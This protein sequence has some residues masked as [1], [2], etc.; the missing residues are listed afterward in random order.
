MKY[1]FKR[2]TFL[3]TFS[4]FLVMGLLTLIPLNLHVLDPLQMALTDISFN[5]LSFA[6]LKRHRDNPMDE[7]IVIVNIGNADRATIAAV[8]NKIDEAQPKAIGLD[9][10]FLAPK[11]PLGDS[12]LA[13]AIAQTPGIVL[14][15]KLE[16]E[17]DTAGTENYFRE[18]SNHGGYV[19]FVGEKLGVI[20]YFSPFEKWKDSVNYSF[21][22]AVVKVSDEL[23]LKKLQKRSHDL[24]L[25]NYSREEDQYFTVDYKDLLSGKTSPPV[26]TNKI[27]LIGFVDNN[28]ANIEDKHFTPLNEKFVGKSIPDMNGV[29][30]HANIISMIL[31]DN[32]IKKSP[33][34]LNWFLAFLLTWFF[35][36]FVIKYYVE[37]HLWSHLVLKTIQLLITVLFI[38]L[39]I[40]LG[41]YFSMEVSLTAAMAG[42]ILSV[43]V[44]YFYVGFAIWAHKKF[45]FKNLFTKAH[46]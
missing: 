37:N 33:G 13:K 45:G 2:D 32:Y 16:F 29:I 23:K 8:V 28:P 1:F 30:I 9:V 14:S 25:I 43:D 11:E 40:M 5:D 17:N 46:Q 6:E 44:L 38:Y 10:L 35:M 31:E 36:A 42:I 34:W 4:V 18:Y 39:A 20:R 41:K 22:A 7:K 19:N 12:L 24:E 15:N 27:V 26:F 21:A 3:A